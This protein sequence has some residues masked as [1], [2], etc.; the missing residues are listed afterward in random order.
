MKVIY[1]PRQSG[2]T[3]DLIRMSAN[4]D[5]VI[6][7]SNQTNRENIQNKAEILG[8]N[9]P[10]PI[11]YSQFVQGEYRSKKISKFLIDDAEY[12]LEILGGVIGVEAITLTN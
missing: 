11:T 9:I 3:M 5:K 6:V 2:K 1:K 7:C 4:T 10:E 12:L 8:L